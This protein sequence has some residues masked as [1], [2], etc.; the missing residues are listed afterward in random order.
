MAAASPLARFLLGEGA[1][2]AG[3]RLDDV[4]AMDD[5]A[6]ER[7]HDYIQWLFPLLVPSAAV[8]DAPVLEAAE[9]PTLRHNEIVRENILRAADRMAD[10]YAA[11]DHWLVPADHNHLRITRIIRALRLLV[12]HEE[13][14]DFH[15]AM[16]N[17]V[18]HAGWPIPPKS[19]SFWKD[20]LR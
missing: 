14:R 20:A 17:R 2:A 12:G 19:L 9:I 4:L 3:R 6:L 1:D 5:D 15:D 8:P 11:N 16:M 10:F 18:A 7:E 13:A